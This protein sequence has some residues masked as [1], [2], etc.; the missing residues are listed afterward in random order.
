MTIATNSLTASAEAF[1]L[2][3]T[4]GAPASDNN[5][6]DICS[7]KSSGS[8]YMRLVCTS[9]T[10]SVAY[11]YVTVT[12]DKYPISSTSFS[13]SCGINMTYTGT[14]PVSGERVNFNMA[15]NN[16]VSAKYISSIGYIGENN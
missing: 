15:L 7:A 16:Y 6:S 3:Y 13:A 8:S 4:S 10:Q 9:F 14:K 12:C 5:V 11:G 2:H 1:N